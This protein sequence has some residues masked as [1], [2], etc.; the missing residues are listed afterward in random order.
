[1]A[2]FEEIDSVARSLDAYAARCNPLYSHFAKD[3]EEFALRV[4]V[5]SQHERVVVEERMSTMRAALTEC[6][7]ALEASSCSALTQIKRD[8][9]LDAARNAL[10]EP[11]EA[12]R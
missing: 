3:L 7:E 8:C 10:A 12:A 2:N 1:M 6:I 9:A 5:A 11:E 4:R